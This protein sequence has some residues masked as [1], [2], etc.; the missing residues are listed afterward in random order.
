LWPPATAEDATGPGGVLLPARKKL[1]GWYGLAL[2]LLLAVPLWF[3]PGVSLFARLAL[4]ML[5]AALFTEGLGRLR[6][7]AAKR[8]PRRPADILEPPERLEEGVDQL[9]GLRAVFRTEA[10]RGSEALAIALFGLA[11]A[12]GEGFLLEMLRDGVVSPKLVLAALV[13]PFAAVYTLYRAA[14]YLGDGRCVLIFAEGLVCI[15]G[16][17]MEVHFREAVAGVEQVELG[18]TIDERAVEIRLKYGKPPLRFTCSHFRN[19]DRFADR[20][21]RA[22]YRP[23]P[24][25]AAE[26]APAACGT[27]L[28]TPAGG[29]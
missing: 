7:E 29:E 18:D 15:H 20:V 27:V 12:C 3:L 13:A 14:R 22:I 4:T 17:R 19:L 6:L 8:Q 28:P 11:F 23:A 10:G 25:P 5:G 26:A 21:R 2:G 24:P 9:G 1:S 16:R